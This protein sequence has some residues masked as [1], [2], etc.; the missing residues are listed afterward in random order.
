MAAARP[1]VYGRGAGV[2]RITIPKC[3]GCGPW[4]RVRAAVVVRGARA[5]KK[6]PPARRDADGRIK[7]VLAV[8]P[9]ERGRV[10]AVRH[11]NHPGPRRTGH[12]VP[13]S[14][15]ARCNA[16]AVRTRRR[17]SIVI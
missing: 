8:C 17:H 16:A 10:R 4:G 13:N 1:A 2:G 6:Q 12:R 7:R 11:R 5:R 14:E 15:F 9:V 3:N